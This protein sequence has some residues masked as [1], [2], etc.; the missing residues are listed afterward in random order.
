MLPC[1]ENAIDIV[2]NYKI[3]R[4]E[5][6]LSDVHNSLFLIFFYNLEQNSEFDSTLN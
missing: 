6:L 5:N 2:K 3:K 1:R 4:H